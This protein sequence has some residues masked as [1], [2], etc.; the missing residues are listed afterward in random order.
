MPE[1]F[2]L[3]V[4]TLNVWAL[5]VP[6]PTQQKWRR[7]N[8]LPRALA[9]LDADIVVLQELFDLRARRRLLRELC[10]PYAAAPDAIQARRILGLV[11]SD[12]TGGLL[13]L[14]RLPILSSRFVPHLREPGMK[15]DERLGQKGALIVQ[16]DSPIGRLTILAVHLYAG[17]R[18]EDGRRRR[19]QLAR[20]LETLHAEADPGPILLAGDINV[21][22]TVGFS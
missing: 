1:V 11:P 13:V 6:I 5:P 8:R 2:P 9:E 3:R 15:L 4:V 19:A 21:S 12:M 16:V 10:P 7:L 17:T 14:S 20:L 18:P 22:P